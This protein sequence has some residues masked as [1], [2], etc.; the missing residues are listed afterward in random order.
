MHVLQ[1]QALCRFTHAACS[2]GSQRL[3]K[4]TPTPRTVSATTSPSENDEDVNG[5][6]TPAFVYDTGND[7]FFRK[8]KRDANHVL[9][10]NSRCSIAA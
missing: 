9:D 7:A 3:R 4:R 6:F 8:T 10:S 5:G 2:N 1:Q